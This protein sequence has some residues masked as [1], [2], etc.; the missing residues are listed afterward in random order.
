MTKCF[1][2]ENCFQSLHC[3]VKSLTWLETLKIDPIACKYSKI[4]TDVTTT[5][6][7][8]SVTGSNNYFMGLTTTL[9]PFQYVKVILSCVWR[10]SK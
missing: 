10:D 9:L 6:F 1:K 2:A 5:G 8:S 4:L 7:N 3:I